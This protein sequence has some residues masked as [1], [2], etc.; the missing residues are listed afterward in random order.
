MVVVSA[1]YVISFVKCTTQAA[2][3]YRWVLGL[4]PTLVMCMCP[5]VLR[6]GRIG[7]FGLAV[8]SFSSGC[9]LLLAYVRSWCV[10]DECN[11]WVGIRLFILVRLILNT[12]L[13]TMHVSPSIRLHK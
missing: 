9:R 11:R 7:W 12:E 8:C 1:V 13:S 3:A 4:E 5:A 10:G 2:R 6:C